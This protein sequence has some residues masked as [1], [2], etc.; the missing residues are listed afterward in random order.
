MIVAYLALGLIVF[1]LVLYL[2]YAIVGAEKF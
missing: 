1:G 2:I